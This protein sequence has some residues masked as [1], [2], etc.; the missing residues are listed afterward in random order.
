M[1]LRAIVAFDAESVLQAQAL[2]E[3]FA[4]AYLDGQ[5]LDALKPRTL[6]RFVTDTIVALNEDGVLVCAEDGLRLLS[7]GAQDGVMIQADFVGSTVTYRREKGGGRS[8]MIAKAVGLKP[9]VA[10]YVL[11]ATAGLGGDAFVLA[12]LGCRLSLL[13]RVPVV[14]ALLADGLSRGMC[15]AQENDPDLAQIL[16]A[17]CLHETDAATYLNQLEGDACPDVVYLDPMFPERSKSA[18]VKKEMRVFHHLV[19]EDTDADALLPLSLN[20]ARYRVVVKRPRLAPFLNET[21]PSHSLTGKRNRFDVY[22]IQGMPGS[23]G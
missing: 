14:R 13:E 7:G 4:V 23:L 20:K 12:S 21:K 16:G 9:G 3:R 17:M 5:N 18:L 2:S 6:H 10:P 11:D 8:Q 15:V 19:G 22:V 1:D